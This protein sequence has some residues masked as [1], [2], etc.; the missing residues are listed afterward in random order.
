M[1]L[2]VSRNPPEAFFLATTFEP[3]LDFMTNWVGAKGARSS[4]AT[5]A[6][7]RAGARLISRLRDRGWR[8]GG[9]DHHRLGE[10]RLVGQRD[11][12]PRGHALGGQRLQTAQG[13][14]GQPHARLA[15]GQVDDAE[16][17]P[18][19]AAA[20][21]GA[22]RL[23][24]GLLGGKAPGVARPRIGAALAATALG[25]GEDAVEKAVAVARDRRL[26]PA[27][28]D[29]IAADAEDHRAS[30]ARPFDRVDDRRRPQG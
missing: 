16:T 23:G 3:G 13:A 7:S 19:H 12:E 5:P 8:N 17:A 4:Q 2:T 22:E 24:G 15:R 28:V 20:K 29:Q 27:D 18:E 1:V 10:R 6:K 30:A 21:P 14:T 26:D 25:L 9:D 11:I